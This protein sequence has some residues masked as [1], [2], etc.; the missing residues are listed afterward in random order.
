MSLF[1]DAHRDRFGVEPICRA[2]RIAPS[3]YYAGKERERNPCA[4]ALRDRGSL[5]E[6][7]R[8][9]EE[10]LSVYGAEKTWRRLRREGIAAPRCQVERL[11]RSD[12]LRGAIR[13]A[14]RI[15][16]TLLD[17]EAERP[18]DLVDRDLTATAPDQLWVADLTYV[19][20]WEAT[21]YVAFVI[22]VFGRRIVGRR[23]A[24]SMK[25]ELVLD[26]IEMALWSRDHEGSPVGARLIHHS[27]A[28]SQY[29]SFAF[30]RRLIEAG[31]DP[32]VGSVGDAYD[33]ALAESTIGLF[34]TEMIEPKG[35]WKTV[36]DVEPATLTWVDWFNHRRLHGACGDIPPVEFEANYLAELSPK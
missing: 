1:I 30:T 29:T 7:R 14:K 17:G 20:A 16:T 4:R 13:G 36:S 19:A 25:T 5:P 6:I 9:H 28:G 15:R 10:N 21:A 32:S 22:D 34:K 18:G 12:G 23:A 27:D 35:P 8:V 2:P 3:T 24:R 31:V 26:T 33:N 11:M